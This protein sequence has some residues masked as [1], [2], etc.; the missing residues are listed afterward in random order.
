M[1]PRPFITAT[2]VEGRLDQMQQYLEKLPASIEASLKEL[3]TDL[4]KAEEGKG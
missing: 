2:T 3:K 1:I 4:K